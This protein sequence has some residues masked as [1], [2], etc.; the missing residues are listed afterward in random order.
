MEDNNIENNNIEKNIDNTAN[1]KPK[2]NHKSLLI[3]LVIL[4]IFNAVLAIGNIF[5][6]IVIIMGQ[7]KVSND[8]DGK[9][10]S[11]INN[12]HSSNQNDTDTG[13]FYGK[14]QSVDDMDQVTI[15]YG[16]GGKKRITISYNSKYS[17]RED[18][19]YRDEVDDEGNYQNEVEEKVSDDKVLNIM[20]YIYDN[21]L[22]DLNDYNVS[23]DGYLINQNDM[24]WKIEV[25]S[26]GASCMAY[27]YGE[28]PDW[29]NE[30]L[31]KLDA[32]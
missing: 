29:F 25:D 31:K 8:R 6:N 24:V 17:N 10:Y 14:P 2:Q 32:N 15:N 22:Q 26:P 4:L 20:K 30:L 28:A 13:H 16:E 3:C 5:L 21:D 27:G 7:M 11:E 19:I 18:L 23:S 9:S 12:G 1:Q